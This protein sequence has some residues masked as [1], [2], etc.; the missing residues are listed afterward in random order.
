M[1]TDIAKAN[2]NLPSLADFAGG[3]QRAVA[4]ELQSTGGDPFL[5]LLKSGEWVYGQEDTEIEPESE[6]AWNPLSLEHGYVSWEDDESKPA[7][8][9]GESMDSMSRPLPDLH[10]LGSPPGGPWQKQFS[11]QVQCVSGEDKGTQVRYSGTSS[12]LVDAFA[13][14]VPRILK[15]ITD[16]ETEV[17]PVTTL[18]VT[19]Y[20]HKRWGTVYKPVFH[21]TR[22]MALGEPEPAE[23]EPEPEPARKRRT[24]EPAEPEAAPR[25]RRRKSA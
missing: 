14:M 6:W 4:T 25:R 2:G 20:Q 19:S 24:A 9:L 16:G 17:V 11:V 18:D 8:K 3:L 12:G 5:R 10:E 21:V 23:P 15:R 13:A 1:T 22:W 7:K